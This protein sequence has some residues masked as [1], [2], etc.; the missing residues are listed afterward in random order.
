M[1]PLR[2]KILEFIH[3]SNQGDIGLSFAMVD[4]LKALYLGGQLKYD[5]TKPQWEERD[6]VIVSSR[7]AWPAHFACLEK[8]GFKVGSFS[9]SKNAA[10]VPGVEIGMDYSGHGLAVGLGVARSLKM[11]KK[12]NKVYVVLDD[13]DLKT[14]TTWE[15]IMEAAYERLSNLIVIV[16]HN[17]DAKLDPLQ[18]KFEAFEWRVKK[19]VNGHNE[20]EVLDAIYAAKEKKRKPTL[21]LAPTVLGKGV[22]F[23]EGKQ[24]YRRALFSEAELTEAVKFLET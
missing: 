21:I 17:L 18:D 9:W 24:E 12:E 22:P 16:S 23:A 10:K 4:L 3:E 7:A 14:G 6:Y 19:L 13:D 5:A 15:A 11:S 2:L 8:A 1:N 20:D